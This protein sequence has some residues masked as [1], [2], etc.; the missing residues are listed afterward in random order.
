M[1]LIILKFNIKKCTINKEDFKEVNKEDFK[2]VI[3]ECNKEVL[4]VNKEVSNKEVI[5]EVFNN[6]AFNN[7]NN[8]L[9]SETGKSLLQKEYG[10]HKH[11]I[12]L[13]LG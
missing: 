1:N 8:L 9:L 11:L 2:E 3:K 7:N 6:K 4:K 12:I 10:T 13:K 5:K